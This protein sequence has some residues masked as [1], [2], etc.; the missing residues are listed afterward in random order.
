MSHGTVARR[1]VKRGRTVT[2]QP[3]LSADKPPHAHVA[4]RMEQQPTKLWYAGSIPA[5][6]T[7]SVT[8]WGASREQVQRR[9]KVEPNADG[10]G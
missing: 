6:G 4:Q 8:R 3:R 2:H 5:V 9:R 7:L 10:E 1:I